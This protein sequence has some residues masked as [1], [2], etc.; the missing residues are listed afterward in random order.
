MRRPSSG[1]RR[2][3]RRPPA[4]P[5]G[6][7]AA[8]LPRGLRGPV[9]GGPDGSR[10]PARTSTGWPG[11]RADGARRGL[12]AD[13]RA[14]PPRAPR[15]RP[16]P[17]R[18]RAPRSGSG[19]ASSGPASSAAGRAGW[20]A[21]SGCSTREATTAPSAVMLLLP[22]VRRHLEARD[23]EAARPGRGRG[24][25]HRRAVRGRDLVAFARNFEGQVL[26]RSERI[27]EGLAL[28]DEAMVAVS[29]GELSPIVTGSIYCM[30]IRS[31]QDVYALGRAREWTEALQAWCDAQPG[32]VIFAGHCLV[33]RSEIH[34]WNGE[35]DAAREEARVA[36][37]RLLGGLNEREAAPA[38]YQQAELHRLR[39]EVAEA[40]EAYANASRLGRE[41]QPGLALLR[42]AQG[43][44][45]A[46]ASTMRRVVQAASNRLQQTRLL[47]AHVEVMLAAGD[48]DEARR[49]C[50]L[51]QDVAVELRH[52]GRRRDGRARPRRRASG[53][54]R[55]PGRARAASTLLRDLAEARRA[56]PR[57]KGARARRARL[58]PAS[59]T[60]TGA[61]SRSTARE[62]YSASSAPRRT[63]PRST[64]RPASRRRPVRTASPPASSRCCGSWRRAR[65]TRRS[66]RSCS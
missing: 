28:L 9:R 61:I 65:P 2:R 49:A 45:E 7:G 54:G 15:G 20:R 21:R 56:L 18:P 51:L 13:P 3:F 30:V 44:V 66:R 1:R 24:R 47:P 58:P 12:P 29:S 33:H 59:A 52:G 22:V 6:L 32:P 8:K 63:S 60:T 11:R 50:A 5:R 42:L 40:E 36:A 55:P 41:P 26:L 14:R 16:R 17:S 27:P 62:R 31:C 38:F 53:G 25:P 23:Y 34:Q 57:G 10:S 48:L 37:E 35:W 4:R 64:P 19:S 43:R 46:A 39:G